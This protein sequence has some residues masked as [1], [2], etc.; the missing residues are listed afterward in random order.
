MLFT[1]KVSADELIELRAIHRLI[2][3]QAFLYE[4]VAKNT[5]KVKKGLAWCEQMQDILALLKEE[6]NTAVSIL[7]KKYGFKEGI[8]V[9]IDLKNG[10]IQAKKPMADVINKPVEVPKDL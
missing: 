2:T 3:E 7:A 10:E 9:S 1:K 5:F 6:Q 8:H 4:T